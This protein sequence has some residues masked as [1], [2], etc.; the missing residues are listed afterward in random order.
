MFVLKKS[1][2]I[3]SRWK[4][5]LASSINFELFLAVSYKKRVVVVARI[6]RDDVYKKAC[7]F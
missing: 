3:H 1:F 5:L 6:D 4:F 7:N 2:H